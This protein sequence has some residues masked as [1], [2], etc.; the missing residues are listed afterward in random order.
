MTSHKAPS[1]SP[2]PNN[3]G[4]RTTFQICNPEQPM[5]DAAITVLAQLLLTLVEERTC[6][7]PRLS[8]K[9]RP[10]VPRPPEGD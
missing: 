5:S 8:S 1:V 9:I 2:A 4:P 7:T 6:E 10:P 3:T